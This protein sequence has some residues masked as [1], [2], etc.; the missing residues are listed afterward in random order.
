VWVAAYRH[1]LLAATAFATLDQLS[2][3]RVIVGVGAGHVAEEFETLGVDFAQRGRLL[4]EAIDALKIALAEE[5]PTFDGSHWSFAD[6]GVGPRPLQHPRPPVWVGGTSPAAVRWAGERGDGWLPQGTPRRDMPAQIAA[7]RAHR[8]RVGGE[9]VEIGAI[10]EFLYVGTP[11]WDVGR[12][13]LA[14]AP[15]KIA[16]SLR[17]FKDMGV[18][19][20]Q[21][22]F[23]AR[24]VEEHADQLLAFGAEVAPLLNG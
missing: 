2:K 8:E 21:V 16:S 11:G 14:G 22:R 5:F 9:P 17:E 18:S 10:G 3:G 20:V 13:T 1:R 6:V 19:H 24:S 23:R 15:E 7:I 4:D 12:G